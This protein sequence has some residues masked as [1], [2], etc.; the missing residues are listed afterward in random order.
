MESFT[1]EDLHLQ[2]NS[3]STEGDCMGGWMTVAN[4]NID[5]AMKEG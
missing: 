3:A 1:A 5:T 4:R 2:F